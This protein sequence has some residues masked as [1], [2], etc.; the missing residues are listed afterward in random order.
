MVQILIE[1][2]TWLI[3]IFSIIF[4]NGTGSKS[5]IVPLKDDTYV[6]YGYGCTAT[7]IYYVS[8]MQKHAFRCYG[9]Y[10]YWKPNLA[11]H[12]HF[13]LIFVLGTASKS[14]IIA[15]LTDA[16]LAYYWYGCT[17]TDIYYDIKKQKPALC[18][19][20]Y[21]YWKPNWADK[22]FFL[23]FRLQQC[24]KIPIVPLKDGK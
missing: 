4:A 17:A 3:S 13:F 20:T 12:Q 8:Q 14:S 16:K 15:P 22:Q 18:Y 5:P 11:Y 2:Q 1:S 24:V 9:T 19:G 6:C 10:I 23:S 21:I 7:D